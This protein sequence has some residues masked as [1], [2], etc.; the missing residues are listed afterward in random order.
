MRKLLIA[1]ILLLVAFIPVSASAKLDIGDEV[2]INGKINATIV[3]FRDGQPVYQA[4]VYP[5][6]YSSSSDGYAT[7]GGYYPL[8]TTARDMV[9]A[10]VVNDVGNTIYVENIGVGYKVT[11]AYLYFDTSVLTGYTVTGASIYVYETPT[12]NSQ[13]ADGESI[14]V[15]SGMPTYP[16]T[17]L[18]AGD[19][20][21]T[22]YAGDGGSKAISTFADNS[23]NAIVLNATGYGWI[24]TSG[25][26]K[27]CLR[28]TGDINNN[29]P[30]GI[31]NLAFYSYEQGASYRPYLSVTFTALSPTIVSSPASNVAVNTA[32]L[33]SDITEDGGD[34]DCEVRY[35]YGLVSHAVAD[36]ELYTTKTA[37]V[38][39]YDES[40]NP[41]LDVS[42]LADSS[43]YYFRAQ[44]RNDS[45]NMT[46]V[47]E[48]TFTTLPDVQEP[49]NFIGFPNATS[50]SLS[51]L[52]GIGSTRTLIRH[53]VDTFPTGTTDGAVT[54]NGTASF[55]LH[56][57]LTEGITYYYSAWGESGGVYSD[58]ATY[59]V[60]TTSASLD[61]D[62]IPAG[63]NPPGW[64]Q[65]PDESFLAQ[66][67]PFYS[68]INGLADNASMP[69]GNA[70]FL[71]TMG[72][73]LIC[74]LGIYITVHAPAL[75]LM[76]M[77]L[78]MAGGVLLHILDSTMIVFVIF[79]AL[80]AWSARPQGV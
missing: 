1:G 22:N 28:T 67:Q 44:V 70:W 76:V 25:T 16:H 7:S 26:T 42:S 73:I 38:A 31:N 57:G 41:Y 39:G 40:E 72:F 21:Q 78:M 48:Q 61:T 14:R 9:N 54:Y 49:L 52:K 65:T 27:Y 36:F 55:Y 6:I 19:F 29:A 4:V 71:L 69:R 13:S 23:Y 37:W 24:N 45:A 56:T 46:S 63:S 17:P 47:D 32:R 75:A 10:P 20:D 35:G 62:D 15:Q 59:L 43:T 64:F 12:I 66:L 11:K 50:I 34:T 5:N 30:T 8:Y 60:M 33:N 68:V 2:L 58:N 18:V 53:R 77:A 3:D 51:W 80:G 74:G 79:L